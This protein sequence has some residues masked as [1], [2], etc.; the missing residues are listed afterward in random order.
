MQGAQVASRYAKSL[1]NLTLDQ[2]ILEKAYADMKLINTICKGNRDFVLMLKSPIIKTDKK[3][4]ILKAILGGKVQPLTMEF[5]QVI[6]R[7]K[8]ESYIEGIAESFVNQYKEHKKILTAVITTAFGLDDELRKKVLDVVKNSEK[9]EVELIEKIDKNILGGFIIR[10]GDK[11][12]DTSIL[13]KIKKLNRV[14]NENPYIK[15]F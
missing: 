9:S 14:F 3:E 7:K 8:R 1:I 2:G 6:T 5:I 12:D 4:A 13:R 11:Q 10:V 15:E